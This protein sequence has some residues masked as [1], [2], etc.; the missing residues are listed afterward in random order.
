MDKTTLHEE[1]HAYW[2]NRAAG[3]SEYNQQELVDDRRDKWKNKLLRL[4]GEQFPGRKA[5]EIHVL[6]IGTGPGFFALLLAEAGYQVSAVDCTE[7]MLREAAVNAGSYADQ[8]SWYLGDVQKLD[9]D[10]ESFDILVTRNVTWNLEH[11][12]QAYQE[13][14]RILKKGGALFN[15]DADWYGYLFDE[16]KKKGYEE[17]RKNT[18]EQ[19]VVDLNEGTDEAAME[20]IARQVPLS[21]E[22][23]PQWDQTA[24]KDAGFDQ[25]LCDPEVWKEVWGRDDMVNCASSPLFLMTGKKKRQ[26]FTLGGLTAE[27]GEKK[28]G[29]VRLSEEISL[30]ATI[31]HGE[32]AGKTVLITAGVHAAEYVGIQASVELAD[33]L[34]PELVA[35]TI[36]ILKVVN[37]PAFEHRNGSLGLS[38]GKNLNRVFPGNPDGSEMDRLAAAMVAQVFP[39]IDYYIDL[40]SGDA[41]EQLTPYV[42]Y[43]GKAAPEVSAASRKMAEQVDVPYMV[44]SNTATGGAYNYA[45]SLGI[46]G[47]LIE[48]GGMGA[49]TNEEA[50]STRRDVRNILCSLGIY[51]SIMDYRTYYPL[52]VEDVIYQD[53]AHTGLWYR[54]KQA[55]DIFTQG[56]VLGEV[57]DYQGNILE[58]CIAEYDGV[59]L[60]QTASLQVM[61]NTPMIAYGRIVHKYDD[62]KERIVHYWSKRSESF[63]DQRRTELHSTMAD[64]WLTEIDKYIPQGQNLRILDVGCGAG[65]FSIL[66]A[67]RGHEVIGI[68]LTPEMIEK[69]RILASEEQVPCDF[70]IMDAENPAFSDESFDFVITRNLTWTLPH[71][72]HAYEQWLRVLKKGGV[73]LNFDANYGA[74]DDTDISNLPPMHA[75]H[76]IGEDMRLENEAIKRQLPIS[77]HVRP[78]WDVDTLGKLGVMEFQ[79]DR[80][81]SPRIYLDKDEL[82]NPVPMFAIAVKK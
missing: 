37:R 31:I 23:R 58:V 65:F 39:V 47:I 48:R 32:K 33:T 16:E 81:I 42:Y 76:M 4:I 49:W 38:D 77:S 54:S 52:D 51:L 11:P 41:F 59:V 8:I 1:I 66:L 40:H 10:D 25:V 15:F 18:R 57:C 27:A 46:P 71:V 22:N 34:Q 14:Y 12:D 80:G 5:G 74:E 26:S 62:R 21:R 43:A 67:A 30:P 78:A 69:A 9:F 13:W 61:E 55:G 35:G 82:Y 50:A 28:S 6:D 79:I 24:M 73:L 72:E 56:E 53:A 75:H 3:Y 7:E 29:F 70:F 68:D 60:Y 17:D 20:K 45:A 44:K 64:R 19:D 63:L 2:T 36:V